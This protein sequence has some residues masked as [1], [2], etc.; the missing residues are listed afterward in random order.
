[1]QFDIANEEKNVPKKADHENEDVH[2][3]TAQNNDILEKFVDAFNRDGETSL[4]EEYKDDD[5]YNDGAVKNP[6]RRRERAKA[7]QMERFENEP[8]QEERRRETTRMIL[9]PADPAT[10][11]YLLNLYTGKCQICGN[12]FPQ[13]S[14]NPFFVAGQIVERKNARLL[15]NPANTLCLC[16]LHFAQWRHGKVEAVDIIGQ[17]LSKKNK[18]EGGIEDL[19]LKI[20]LC[21]KDCEIRYKEKHIVDL[22]AFLDTIS[23][24]PLREH[25][26]A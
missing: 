9:E 5:Y 18:S 11:A 2:N 13:R 3:E 25:S 20:A 17:I 19:S 6:T 21:G 15:D 22:Q 4:S 1:V 24:S 14:G 10:R 16:P 7:G 12:T 26:K 8:N 23:E